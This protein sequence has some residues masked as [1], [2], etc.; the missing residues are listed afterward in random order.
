MYLYRVVLDGGRRI[1]VWSSSAEPA[2]YQ[3]EVV[4]G[5]NGVQHLVQRVVEPEPDDGVDGVIYAAPMKPG[6][7]PA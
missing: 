6:G 3:P 2:H 7:A 1:V 4:F 5:M